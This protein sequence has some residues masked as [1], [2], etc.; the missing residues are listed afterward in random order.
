M[1]LHCCTLIMNDSKPK[2]FVTEILKRLTPKIGATL[3]LEPEFEY[4]GLITFASGKRVF[5]RNTR[6]NINPLG[7]VEVAKDKNYASFFLKQF[8]YQ[9]PEG[10]TFFSE[11]WNEQMHIKRNIDDGYEY[12]KKLGFPVIVKPNNFSQGLFVTKVFNKKEYY[13]VAKKIFKATRVMIVEKFYTGNDFR[14]VVLDGKII[15]AYQRIPLSITGDGKNTV[16]ELIKKMQS[17]FQ[18][19]GRDTI[20]DPDD[21]RISLKLKKHNLKLQSIIPV[22]QSLQLLDNANL[23]TGGMSLD[24]TN[25]IHP[26]FAKLAT[27]IT[28]DMG[29]KLCG[30]DFMTEDITK[31]PENYALIEINSAPGLDNYASMGKEQREIVDGL[32][33]QILQSL[34]NS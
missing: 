30:V 1:P 32:Y 12:A 23:S 3:L 31:P 6:F 4:T 18:D 5:Y 33:L 15:S 26:G 22:N 28:A 24:F 8:G 13:R 19:N 27:E 25:S 9:V 17:E 11:Q 20:I 10:Q 34:E 29:L 7:S 14:V 21:Y 16:L 2:N